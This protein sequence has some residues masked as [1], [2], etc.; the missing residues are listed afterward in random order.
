LLA[1]GKNPAIRKAA[2]IGAAF[3]AGYQINRL[4]RSGALPQ[5]IDDV[6]NVYRV[7]HKGSPLADEWVATNWVRESLTVISGVYGFLYSDEE[8]G[9]REAAP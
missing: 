5:I 3:G 4:A 6:K 7:A 1:L 9:K 2:L 8:S